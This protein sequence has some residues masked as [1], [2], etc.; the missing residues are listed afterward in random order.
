MR[1]KK[2]E[3]ACPKVKQCLE[4][5]QNAQSGSVWA[6]IYVSHAVSTVAHAIIS[7]ISPIWF[8]YFYL[9]TVILFYFCVCPSASFRWIILNV[10]SRIVFTD[11]ILGKYITVTGVL[12]RF[13]QML[14]LY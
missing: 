1:N 13:V 8:F 9:S 4:E 10:S 6:A 2:S 5:V 7:I 14:S 11:I 12:F 3:S